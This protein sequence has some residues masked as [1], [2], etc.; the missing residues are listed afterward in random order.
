MKKI[1]LAVVVL[2]LVGC[3]SMSE[4]RSQPPVKSFTSNHPINAL[5]E[6]IL[7]G[8]QENSVRYGDVYIQPS[9]NGKTVYSQA[10]IEMAD[11]ISNGNGSTVNF[12]H[13]SGLFKYRIDSRI[14]AI[15]KCVK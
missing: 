7:F 8:W 9:K 1:T 12:Y 14:L 3:S 5:S 6:C 10:N 4:L 2:S 11:I 15:E 13:Q